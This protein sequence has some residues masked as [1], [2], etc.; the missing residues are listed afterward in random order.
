MK[1]TYSK[2]Q[3]E[4]LAVETELPLAMSVNNQKGS[5]TQLSR[6][7][8]DADYTDDILFLSI[9]MGGKME[10]HLFTGKRSYG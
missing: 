2:P 5:G 9:F 3:T 8:N 4:V 1:R 7:S 10:G 6:E